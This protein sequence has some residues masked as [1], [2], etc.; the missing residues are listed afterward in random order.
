MMKLDREKYLNIA[1]QEG[2]STALTALHHDYRDV[3]FHSFEGPE[4]YLPDEWKSLQAIRDFSREI[5]G[6]DLAQH[7]HSG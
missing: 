5:W 2:I 1:R 4:G 3:E 6:I 7:F